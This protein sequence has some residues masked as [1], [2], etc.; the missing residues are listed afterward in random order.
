M[1]LVTRVPLS[2]YPCDP[3]YQHRVAKPLRLTAPFGKPVNRPCNTVA[4]GEGSAHD[5]EQRRRDGVGVP[6][7]SAHRRMVGDL[8]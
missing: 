3:G 6:G 1:T 4:E 7:E 8:A 2:S 5:D